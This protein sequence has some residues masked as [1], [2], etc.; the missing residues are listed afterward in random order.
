MSNQKSIN[1]FLIF[2]N[3]YIHE[4]NVNVSS[5]CSREIVYSKILQSNWPRANW[6]IAETRF[7]PNIGL[8]EERC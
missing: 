5:T 6:P 4:K 3:L 8:A 1:H 2:L 7:F